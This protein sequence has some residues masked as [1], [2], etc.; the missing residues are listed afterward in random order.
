VTKDN[1]IG[2]VKTPIRKECFFTLP[3]GKVKLI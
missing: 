2:Q 3:Y 1:P